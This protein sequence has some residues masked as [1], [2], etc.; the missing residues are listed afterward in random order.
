MLPSLARAYRRLEVQKAELLA[1]LENITDERLAYKP[2]PESWS[3][4]EIVDHLIKTER[5]IMQQVPARLEKACSVP[6]RDRL[7]GTLVT[8]LFRTPI[9]VKVPTAASAAIVP[10]GRLDLPSLNARWAESRRSTS[11]IL[12][13]VPRLPLR[14]AAFRHPVTGWMDLPQTLRFLSAHITHH[15]F[16]VARLQRAWRAASTLQSP[17]TS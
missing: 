7:R 13:Q 3:A 14:L 5:G 6:V 10:S 16:Q 15:N 4:L 8:C 1:A 9:R 11:S 2:S 17:A 12:E